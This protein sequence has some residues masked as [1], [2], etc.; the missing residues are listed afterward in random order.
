MLVMITGRSTSKIASSSFLYNTRVAN[1]PP[2]DSR[3]IASLSHGVR[4][5][6]LSKATTQ[7]LLAVTHI[8]GLRAFTSQLLCE[9]VV[10]RGLRR[11][12]YDL[13]NPIE[14]TFT[15][16]Y[17]NVFGV[18]FSFM[19]HEEQGDGP[20]P[21]PKPTTRIEALPDRAASLQITWPQVIRIE[22][23]LTPTLR[24]NWA[25]VPVL[26]IDAAT[27]TQIA[28]LAPVVAGKPDVSRVT[29]IQLRDLAER[30][31]YQKLVFEA[32]RKL[33]EEE[34]PAWRGNTDV[35]FGQLIKIVEEFLFTTRLQIT[36]NLFAQ[37][38][39]HRRVL[40]ALSMSKIVQHLKTAIRDGST[41]SRRLVLD[42]SRSSGERLSSALRFSGRLTTQP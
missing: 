40:L 32:A 18:P 12:S 30:F 4:R 20:P 16:E 15:P 35:L 10:G 22:H 36:P 23:A 1:P 7:L 24:V 17:V 26:S 39:V 41:E 28:E 33:F 21:P 2:V 8:M 11:T 19:P 31:R 34:R 29:E 5:E 13:E 42:E 27:V 38:D 6:R 9:Q 14:G 37:S 3:Q 25:D